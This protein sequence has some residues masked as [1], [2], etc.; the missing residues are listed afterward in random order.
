M[1][2][3]FVG[4][5]KKRISCLQK[6]IAGVILIYEH[7]LQGYDKNLLLSCQ[8][9]FFR[10]ISKQNNKTKIAI[11]KR[12]TQVSSVFVLLLGLILNECFC[13]LFGQQRLLDGC[14]QGVEPDFHALLETKILW[15]CVRGR[16]G[17][18]GGI[19]DIS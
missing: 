2:N 15:K 1:L 8:I 12:R 17:V 7:K 5:K 18:V 4:E 13:G 16:G 19:F 14:T 3:F 9:P 6:R 10:G 11:N